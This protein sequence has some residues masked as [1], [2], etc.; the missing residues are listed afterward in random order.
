MRMTIDL[1]DA[2]HRKAKR[3]AARRDSSLK[4]LV[5]HAVKCELSV[6]AP[7]KNQR[8]GVNLPLIRTS[9]G[10]KLDL[11]NFDFDDLLG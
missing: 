2:L 1:P 8:K 5:I 7:A 9:G 10:R 11:T 6:G 4:D 3:V